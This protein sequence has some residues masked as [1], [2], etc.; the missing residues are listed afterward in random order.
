MA[1]VVKLADVGLIY[2]AAAERLEE[3]ARS[4]HFYPRH[5]L[6]VFFANKIFELSVGSTAAAVKEKYFQADF[7]K[8]LSRWEI[9]I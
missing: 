5:S 9:M 8:G 7:W 3:L 6:K 1:R 2:F 4:G